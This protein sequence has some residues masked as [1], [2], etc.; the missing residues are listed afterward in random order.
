M[1]EHYQ[2]DYAANGG[3]GIALPTIPQALISDECA[4][5]MSIV[6]AG[7][8]WHL[9]DSQGQVYVEADDPAELAGWLQNYLFALSDMKA[10]GEL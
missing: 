2:A 5:V 4:N 6:F 7:E 8:K 1:I 10:R 3:P 9:A